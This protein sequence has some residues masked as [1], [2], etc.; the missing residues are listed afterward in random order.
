MVYVV[1]CFRWLNKMYQ[2]KLYHLN[3]T[4]CTQFQQ[5]VSMLYYCSSW[6]L[7]LYFLTIVCVLFF[8]QCTAFMLHKI[9][10]AGWAFPEPRKIWALS[11]PAYNSY[12]RDVLN[13]LPRCTHYSAYCW[14]QPKT[15]TEMCVCSMEGV[16]MVMTKN[17]IVKRA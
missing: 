11:G 17:D 9:A 13:T 6:K 4:S 10:A 1:K 8:C 16:R 5:L 12:K 14:K 2:C 7:L 15:N 3:S